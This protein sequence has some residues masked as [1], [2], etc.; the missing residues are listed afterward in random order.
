VSWTFYPEPLNI[1][2][3]NTIESLQPG[4]AGGKLNIYLESQ[5]QGVS[6]IFEFGEVK[7]MSKLRVDI[8]IAHLKIISILENILNVTKIHS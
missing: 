6:K 5:I 3:F 7:N 8:D 2:F 4:R 1:V